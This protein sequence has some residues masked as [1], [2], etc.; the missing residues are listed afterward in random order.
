[1]IATKRLVFATVLLWIS[2]SPALSAEQGTASVQK[3]SPRNLWDHWQ[4][5]RMPVKRIGGIAWDGRSLWVLDSLKKTVCQASGRLQPGGLKF[6]KDAAVAGLAFDGKAFW[7]YDP[8]KKCFRSIAPSGIQKEIPWPDGISNSNALACVNGKLLFVSSDKKAIL[9]IDPQT[10]K[11]LGKLASPCPR[12]AD[13]AWDGRYLWCLQ[14]TGTLVGYDLKRQLAFTSFPMK[15]RTGWL[16]VGGQKVW[17]TMRAASKGTDYIPIHS[18]PVPRN[19]DVCMG[20]PE[21][22]VQV[23][24]G[25]VDNSSKTESKVVTVQVHNVPFDEVHQRVLNVRFEPAHSRLHNYEDFSRTVR[26]PNVAIAPR[27]VTS[28]HGVIEYTR[29]PCRYILI[30]DEIGALSDIPE[31]IRRRFT[32]QHDEMKEQIVLTAAKE[33]AG[34]ETN[35]YWKMRSI[36]DWIGENL[37]QAPGGGGPA[38]VLEGGQATCGGY[39]GVMWALCRLNGIPCRTATATYPGANHAWALI[40][41]PGVNGWVDVDVMKDDWPSEYSYMRSRYI[42]R[43]GLQMR[44]GPPEEGPR[45]ITTDDEG[46][47]MVDLKADLSGGRIDEGADLTPACYASP[48]L[49]RVT[50]DGYLELLWAEGYDYEDGTDLTYEVYASTERMQKQR[51]PGLCVASNLKQPFWRV[52][53]LE[54]AESYWFRVVALDKTGQRSADASV[55]GG[56]KQMRLGKPL[57]GRYVWNRKK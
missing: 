46:R 41:L 45:R 51:N 21:R 52:E 44:R 2:A 13:M 4:E 7:T 57:L 3:Q 9:Y 24:A 33:A 10:G 18:F 30:P 17:G 48:D 49:W 23:M 15:E 43:R 1:M 26:I 29:R 55:S 28:V 8:K 42:G 19:G 16:A 14:G 37:H 31:N 38:K 50:P 56:M 34:S 53:G 35:P 22:R 25:A 39:T 5:F 32:Q 27:S 11:L 47:P 54:P 6:A 12:L 36:H 20:E 40:W